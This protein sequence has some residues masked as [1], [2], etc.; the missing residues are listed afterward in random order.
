MKQSIFLI[1]TILFVTGCDSRID[2]VNQKMAEIRKEPPLAIDPPPVFE[3]AP[4]FEYSAHQLRSPFIPN[5]LS[6][7]LK[8]MGGRKVY[9]NL[10]R[11]LQALESYALES[12][13]MKGSLKNKNGKILALIQTPDQEV[14]RIEVGGYLGLNHGRVIKVTPTQVDLIEIIPDGREGYIERPRSLVLIGVSP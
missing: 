2:I 6:E 3:P 14:E 13:S 12:L 5:S 8:L 4:I 11:P 7:E 1:L 9:P 10:T